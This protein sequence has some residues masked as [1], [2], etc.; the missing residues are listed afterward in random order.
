MYL[1]KMNPAGAK[2]MLAVEACGMLTILA[3][4]VM[5]F[6][7]QHS[8]N[9]QPTLQSTRL[10]HWKNHTLPFIHKKGEALHFIF[11]NV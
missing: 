4:N 10:K 6:H 2:G 11:E 9:T 5:G 8:V 3:Q 7:S 1:A